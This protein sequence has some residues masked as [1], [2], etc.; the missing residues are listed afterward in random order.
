MKC[1]ITGHSSGVGQ[2][3]YEHFLSQGWE[4]VGM[5]RSNGYNIVTDRDRIIQE[6][7]GCDLF[8][9]NASD[10]TAQLELL[11]S[12]CTKVP[13]IITLGSAGTDFGDIWNKQY[14]I[15]K[16]EL[17]QVCRLISLSP[18]DDIS[19]LLLIKLSF[20]ETT[21]SREKTNRIGSDCTVS[22][23]EIANII[24]FWLSNPKIRQVDFEVKLT[25][26]TVRQA[27]EMSGN[28]DQVDRLC[29]QVNE[30][31]K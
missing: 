27:K 31:I 29:K 7:I 14:N 23:K 2:S 9:N 12:L 20:A 18:R 25:E 26:E 24:D 4:V 3:L 21:Y 15:N 11:Q 13:K 8:I 30:L 22:Y 28:I 10:G 16:T 5:S 19:K 6:S 1:I 17:E